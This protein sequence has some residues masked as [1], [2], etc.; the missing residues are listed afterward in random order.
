MSE[1]YEEAQ[2]EYLE[3]GWYRVVEARTLLRD[4]E[5]AGV[6]FFIESPH[7]D[8]VNGNVVAAAHG[9]SF[10]AGAEVLLHVHRDDH[11]KFKSI[12]D[13]SFLGEQP[14]REVKSFLQ[15]IRDFGMGSKAGG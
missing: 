2:Q 5:A 12:H 15:R 8:P 13:P 9:G 10:G 14:A 7:S 4:L 3:V 11:E 1:E 6:D